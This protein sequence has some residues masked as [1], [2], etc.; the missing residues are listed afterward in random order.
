MFVKYT[1]V[2]NL[3][4]YWNMCLCGGCVGANVTSVGQNYQKLQ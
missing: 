4:E 1:E 2:N 3:F